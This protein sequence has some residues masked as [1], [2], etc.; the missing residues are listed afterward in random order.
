M[1]KTAHWLAGAAWLMT[2]ST[3]LA[4]ASEAEI[5]PADL[6]TVKI[7]MS[8]GY[9]PFTFVKQDKLQ[10]F[11]VDVWQEIAKRAGYQVE[12]VTASFSGLFGLL[13]SGRI[14]TIANQVTVTPARQ[15]KYAFSAPYVYDGA[16]IVVKQGNSTINGVADLAGKK[17]GV[18]L[19]TNFEALLRA[20]DKAQ[21]MIIRTYDNGIEQDVL[22][23]RLDAFVMDR[24]SSAQ[25]IMQAK[26]PLALA[27][28]PFA[29]IS[30]AWPF[31]K[32]PSQLA[33]R[34]RADAALRSMREDGRLLAISQHWFATDITQP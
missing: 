1:S 13:E 21:T 26:L 14:D 24:V 6:P 17:V 33:I 31:L 8:G 5:A 27:G 3:L 25:L 19:G 9:F 22:L 23:G 10:G 12:F 16:Q 29:P 34:D 28:Q 18:N 32:Q 30:N 11:E 4:A 7:G 20:S 15:A 2:S